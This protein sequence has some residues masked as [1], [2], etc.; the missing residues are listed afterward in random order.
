[1]R[2]SAVTRYRGRQRP[3]ERPAVEVYVVD[4]TDH[5]RC[6]HHNTQECQRFAERN[7]LARRTVP[8]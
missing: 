6:R 5:G 2:C 3:C 4:G 7:G 1:M 8:A